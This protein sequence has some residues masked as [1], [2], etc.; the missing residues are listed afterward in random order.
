M[1]LSTTDKTKKLPGAFQFNNDCLCDMGP[2]TV[3]N[4]FAQ[5]SNT[6]FTDLAH[7][8]GTQN[9]INLAQDMGVNTQTYPNGSSLQSYVN[10]IGLALG[11]AALTI[12]EQDT[13]LATIDNG[14]T[15]HQAHV[16]VSITPPG[17]TAQLGKYATHQVLTTGE[18][19]QVQWAMT[20]VVKNGTA[21]GMIDQA[22]MRPMIAKTGT[23]TSNR[24]AFFI[25]GIPQFALSVGIFTK[26]QGQYLDAAKKIPNKET[27]NNLGNTQQGG[28]GGYWPAKIW[29][30]FADKKFASLPVEQ[31]LPPQF[32]GQTWNQV[33]K[34]PAKKKKP[35]TNNQNQNCQVQGQGGFS[36]P[37]K[38]HR[39]GFPST[40]PS[41]SAST[42]TGCVFPGGLGCPTTGPS[43]SP[44]IGSSPTPTGTPTV[45][46]PGNGGGG[47]V[48]TA[49]AVTS[50]AASGVQV[51]L[52][53]GGVL[54]VLPGSL[55]WNRASRRRRRKHRPES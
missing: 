50:G 16:V 37:G 23:T 34:P 6:A 3:Q 36:C 51:S 19:S 28:F 45:G 8:V 33:P 44:T 24:T 43:S 27:L 31:F 13:M 49:A 40:S 4:A 25:G 41:A 1:A 5:S 32:T 48:A 21:A 14:G 47:K 12:N 26:D 46:G 20:T 17:G 42:S 30:A 54:S 15:Y 10:Q 29:S 7:R 18:A 38:H 9:I 22:S 55:L 11:T 53:A 52:A 35:N 2:L 39:G